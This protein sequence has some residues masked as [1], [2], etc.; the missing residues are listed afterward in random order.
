MIID[1]VSGELAIEGGQ[2]YRNYAN[3]DVCDSNYWQ[4]NNFKR[5]FR[6]LKKQND[7]V[8][9]VIGYVESIIKDVLSNTQVSPTR[10]THFTQV[11][12]DHTDVSDEHLSKVSTVISLVAANVG[13][14]LERNNHINFIEDFCEKGFVITETPKD[15]HQMLWDEIRNTTWVDSKNTSYKKVP[16][17]YTEIK[18]N[19]VDPTGNN[20][21][22]SEKR[23]GYLTYRHSPQSLKDIAHALIADKFFDPIKMYRPPKAI[24]VFLHFWN[25]SEN[26]P[27]HVDAIDGS[28][29]MIFC[30]ATDAG[31]WKEEWG[32]YINV[33]KE[34][35]GEY[36]YTKNVMPE[37]GRMV[38]VNNS[39][40]IFKHG[41]RNLVNENVNRY[42]FIFH[43]TWAYDFKELDY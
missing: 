6:V 17:W 34:V 43:Y 41:I 20:K 39:S 29:L 30:Y 8:F 33:M 3:P 42:T 31:P 9:E 36:H 15:V 37:D 28:D 22:S 19:Y 5:S 27:H 35:N 11:I 10:G 12:S 13:I 40:P 21:P 18:R 23:E 14:V 4:L 7:M 2:Y 26:S 16:D 24:P 38:I 1:I 32:G 25:G